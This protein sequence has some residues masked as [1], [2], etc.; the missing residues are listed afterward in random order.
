[1]MKKLCLAAVILCLFAEISW[2]QEILI[3]NDK[4]FTELFLKID[5]SRIKS[6]SKHGDQVDIFFA[7]NLKA[8]FSKVFE[9]RFLA[10]LSAEGAK[11]TVYLK[12][13]S[14]FTVVNDISGI[15]IVA[16]AKKT[17]HD[18]L[19]SYGIGEPMLSVSSAEDKIS[20]D[21]LDK[22][23]TLLASKRFSD[24]AA[25]LSNIIK[26]SQNDFYRQ[27]AFYKLG[28]TY[29][30]MSQYDD[31]FLV[32]AY[33]TFDD[34]VRLY[35]DNF[36][37][38]D[39]MLKSAETKE[40]ANQLFEAAFAYEK[41]YETV[42]DL[43]T[44]RFALVKMA[45]LYVTV[46]QLEKAVDL[47]KSYLGRFRTD[48]DEI[49]AR[50]GQIYYDQ[51]D[52][53]LA[54]EYFSDLDIDKVI[55]NPSTTPRRLYS[56]ASNMQVKNKPDE[57]LKLYTA[58]YEKF[59]DAPQANDSIFNSAAIL[60][61]TGRTAEAD[62]LLLKL[63]E[64][65]PDRITGQKAA[66]EYAA[67]YLGSKPYSHWMGFF[68]DLLSRADDFGLHQEAK[69][70]LLKSLYSENNLTDLINGA[71]VFLAEYPDSQHK[72]EVDKMREDFMFSRASKTFNSGDM[73]A[74][75]PL[76][77]TFAAEYPNSRFMPRTTAMLL[78]IKFGKAQKLYENGEYSALIS[79][80]ENHIAQNPESRELA[81]WFDLLDNALYRELSIIYASEDWPAAR[82]A[83][84]RY[85]TSYPTGRH[86]KT[87]KE[88]LEKSVISPMESLYKGGD[89]NG[90]VRMYEANK[91]WVE[92]WDNKP[93]KDRAAVLTGLSVYRLGSHEGAKSL[94]SKVSPSS[95]TDYAIL[96]LIVGDRGK[97]FDVNAFDEAT[98]RYVIGEVEQMD[99]DAAVELLKQYTKDLK[100][101][102]SM[103]YG[104][105]KNTPGDAKR[106]ELLMDVYGMITS[107]ESARFEGS[108]DVYLDIGLLYYRKNDFQGA[109]IPLKEY[110]DIH[111][112]KDD[113]R[114]E[115][116]YYLGKSFINMDDPQ[117]GFLFYNEIIE[118]IPKSIYAGIAKSELD[119][120]SWKK[121]LNR[122]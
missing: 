50:I 68:S 90:V 38:A 77:A 52:Q 41:I 5:S 114:A 97:G 67:K 36:R 71:A 106:Q 33:T 32:D 70:L 2:C 116:L 23:D 10:S 29:L 40:K 80:A 105:A 45:E 108:E 88:I 61:K 43:E 44:K 84:R 15:K 86:V 47:Y 95:D 103:E 107:N 73:A 96:G 37:A 64:L 121:N 104:I 111:T 92:N 8:P 3:R 79:E 39:A 28:Q 102:A 30:L 93:F 83:S 9:D 81:R 112:E 18:I 65:F 87:V 42:P 74:A 53:D 91:D 17:N 12:A 78:D 101:A 27:E 22:A 63:K 109:V 113:K 59:P 57:A 6:V 25:E 35:P 118:T 98:L 66:V 19:S 11:L 75:E 60:E 100:L 26:T 34:F 13:G 120:D 49:N 82:V 89:Y 4:Y 20:E 85:L 115:A 24:A 117:R 110:T 94:Y 54:Y 69:Y 51:R 16:A 58:L 76:L 48:R 21:A 99:A 14:E 1:M 56:M 55:K 7:N 72:A 122:F 119:E 46:G 31:S 62:A